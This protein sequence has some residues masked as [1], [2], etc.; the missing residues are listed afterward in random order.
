KLV[1]ELIPQRD[2]S[3][4]PLFQVE[5]VWQNAPQEE[6]RMGGTTV[7]GFGINYGM[8]KFDL[9][10]SLNES[11]ERVSGMA[12]YSTDLYKASSISRLLRHLRRMLETMVAE[13]ERR[14][15][16]IELLSEAERQQVLREW[17]DTRADS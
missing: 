2:L 7:S 15:G 13:R 5:F 12:G 17:N 9:T 4:S 3:R 1:E 6:L 11:R 16:E 10:L 14:V 8:A